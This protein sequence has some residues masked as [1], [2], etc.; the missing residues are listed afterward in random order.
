L[1]GLSCFNFYIDWI[2]KF[3]CIDLCSFKL[4]SM[5]GSKHSQR[6]HKG[7]QMSHSIIK[8]Y[9]YFLFFSIWNHGN[10]GTLLFFNTYECQKNQ[11]KNPFDPILGFGLVKNFENEK[12]YH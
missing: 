11:I 9:I 7:H 2:C 4:H 3:A 10:H 6:S 1:I 12:F 5:F 8:N